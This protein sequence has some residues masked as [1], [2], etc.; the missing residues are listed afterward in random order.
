V[1]PDDLNHE[2]NLVLTIFDNKGRVI[3]RE[4]L[5]FN[6]ETPRIDILG[7]EQGVYPITLSNGK[8]TY[9]GKL[10]VE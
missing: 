3:R 8:T 2:K 6:D 10:V 9:R 5:N 7:A 1:I 4:S